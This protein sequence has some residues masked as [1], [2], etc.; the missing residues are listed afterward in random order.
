MFTGSALLQFDELK[1]LLAQ[2]AGSESGRTQINALEPH[3]DRA[4]LESALA[5][6]G[7]SITYTR[8]SAAAGLRFRQLPDVTPSL[9]YLSIEGVSLGG[10]SILDIFQTLAVSADYRQLLTAAVE[11]YPHLA[12][13]A[14]HLADLRGLIRQYERAF[15][16]EGSLADE[17]SVALKH[18]RRK[19]ER[20]RRA[21]QDS[22]DRF[23]RTHRTD[24]V[25]QENFVTLRDD[26]YVVPIVAGQKGRIDGVIHGSSGTGRTLFVEPLDT[27]DLNNQLVRLREDELREIERILAE[28][29]NALREHREE[30]LESAATLAELDVIFA[31]AEFARSFDAVIPRFSGATRRLLLRE[32]RHPLLEAILRKAAQ[33]DRADHV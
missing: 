7:E 11:R 3:R 21:I 14:L 2:Y 28:I 13:R 16:P 25:L 20:Q 26:R 32:A 24:G 15:L 23:L 22:L 27:I 1:A 12:M 10:R 33:T 5:E 9:R 29:T 6:T 30:I 8:D 17:A 19:I 31:K 18:I 4:L